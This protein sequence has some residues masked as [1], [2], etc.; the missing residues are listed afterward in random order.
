MILS[1][2]Q[3]AK[4]VLHEIARNTY[5]LAMGLQNAAPPQ[6]NNK[7][8]LSIQYLFEAA[9]QLNQF[10]QHLEDILLLPNEAEQQM[11]LC[12]LIKEVIQNDESLRQKY[13]IAGRFRFVQD[14]LQV[15]MTEIEKNL[16]KIETKKQLINSVASDEVAIYV[17]LY[18][19]QGSILRNWQLMI[20]PRVFYE[21]SVNR[22]V[23]VEKKYIEALMHSKT[24]KMHHAYL[25]IAVKSSD[26]FPQVQKDSLDNPIAKVKEG[27]L[28]F[29][30]LISFTHNDQDYVLN[31]KNE[32][33]KKDPL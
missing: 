28:H 21:H 26:I 25:T 11:R 9:I 17:H 18:N 16:P 27:A 31:E 33:V 30:K 13:Q 20:S 15:L 14:K 32:L 24:N 3:S 29:N 22:P 6:G 23:Y 2:M 5:T 4:T 1:D 8:G 12:A 10:S 19:A 7:P